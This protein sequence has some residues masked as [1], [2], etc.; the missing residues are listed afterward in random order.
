VKEKGE[1]KTDPL[2][3]LKQRLQQ[4]VAELEQTEKRLEH[5]NAVLRAIRSVNQLITQER[6]RDR[7]LQGACD[8]LIETCGYRNVWIALLDERG[9]G[10]QRL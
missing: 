7:L 4:R 10:G 5:L 2:G 8:R 3:E 9:G 1:A 6:N